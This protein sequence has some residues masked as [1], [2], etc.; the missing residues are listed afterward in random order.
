MNSRL[1]GCPLFDLWGRKLKP[2]AHL[3]SRQHTAKGV[4]HPQKRSSWSGRAGSSSRHQLPFSSPRQRDVVGQPFACDVLH[5]R[6]GWQSSGT[7]PDFGPL[8]GADP[9]S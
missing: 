6:F 2:R 8:Y 1:A 7:M 3:L 4:K 5:L 9:K